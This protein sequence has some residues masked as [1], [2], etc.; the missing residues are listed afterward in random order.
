MLGHVN[1]RW[2]HEVYTRATPVDRMRPPPPLHLLLWGGTPL[3][4]KWEAMGVSTID[5]ATFR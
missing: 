5:D 3:Q 1:S 4:R 2:A